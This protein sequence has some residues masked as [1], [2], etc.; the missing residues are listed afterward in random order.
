MKNI[1]K[2]I[3]ILA[4][5]TT[6]LG[7]SYVRAA[8]GRV[9]EHV[10]HAAGSAGGS[11]IPLSPRST[12]SDTDKRPGFASP[13][14][15]RG[16]ASSLKGRENRPPTASRIAAGSVASDGVAASDSKRTNVF[17]PRSTKPAGGMG[18]L[19]SPTGRLMAGGTPLTS[20]PRLTAVQLASLDKFLNDLAGVSSSTGILIPKA[21]VPAFQQFVADASE[22]IVAG[23]RVPS[24]ESDIRRILEENA[25]LQK[26]IASLESDLAGERTALA[27]MEALK[28]TLVAN[29]DRETDERR[30]V[31]KRISS[32]LTE[33][34]EEVR[35]LASDITSKEAEIAKLDH[36]KTILATR[37][38]EFERANESLRAES[39]GYQT[40]L[41]KARIALSVAREPAASGAG[42]STR[43]ESIAGG[44]DG[45]SVMSRVTMRSRATRAT[46]FTG[47][48]SSKKAKSI[49]LPDIIRHFA[50]PIDAVSDM[51]DNPFKFFEGLNPIIRIS[52]EE[53]QGY[54]LGKDGLLA[55]EFSEP[56]TLTRGAVGKAMG[57]GTRIPILS[58][59]AMRYALAFLEKIFTGL[60][61]PEVN[62]V[63]K[64]F[65]T[66][67]NAIKEAR[68]DELFIYFAVPA[69]AEGN[70]TD[71]F[72]AVFVTRDPT[73]PYVAVMRAWNSEAMNKN[74]PEKDYELRATPYP[75][76]EAADDGE[77]DSH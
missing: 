56:A 59:T 21:K 9:D 12:A 25:G 6:A 50:Y 43:K 54:K 72:S 32:E 73:Y 27:E 16:S 64:V 34:R 39:I 4:L 70:P 55:I 37:L 23:E 49:E 42:K 71:T 20:I 7:L 33:T 18:G 46:G 30:E 77:A 40:E 22:S 61:E 8:D 19:G 29:E 24:L 76:A 36:E 52:D 38:S 14:F 67:A 10:S 31:V 69:D 63:K 75:D 15:K 26:Q 68:N 45:R 11:K 66:M 47:T 1:I 62:A 17:S 35:R 53:V 13:P 74:Y 3:Q 60:S 48:S 58:G 41:E 2:K 44:D 65:G 51:L 5:A 57:V 28:A